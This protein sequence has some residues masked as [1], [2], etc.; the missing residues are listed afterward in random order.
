MRRHPSL[1]SRTGFAAA[2]LALL[3][4]VSAA[5]AQNPRE[6]RQPIRIIV[7]HAQVV[8]LEAN[9]SV[10]LVANPDVADVVSEKNNLMFVVARKPGSTNLLVYDENGQ[11]LMNREVVVLPD[12]GEE[13][14]VTRELDSPDVVHYFCEPHCVYLSHEEAGTAPNIAPTAPFATAGGAAPA[15]ASPAGQAAA[16]G[17]PQAVPAPPPTSLH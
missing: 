15:A 16:P 1:P 14:T 6:Q 17:A 8:Q 12:T 10:A 7:N 2:G 9:A 5:H 13:V 3:L 4:S 11:P